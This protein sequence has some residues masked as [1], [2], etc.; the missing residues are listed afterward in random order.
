MLVSCDDLGDKFLNE[1][2]VDLE[3]P[4]VDLVLES[5]ILSSDTTVIVYF[6]RT[7]SILEEDASSLITNA[8]VELFLNDVSLGQLEEVVVNSWR[9]NEPVSVYQ[10]ELN[11][12]QIGAGDQI[13]LEATT[14]EGEKVSAIEQMP[15]AA[16]LV[17]ATYLENRQTVGYYY[18]DNSLRVVIDDPSEE[19][20][21]YVFI[22]DERYRD[23]DPVSSSGMDTIEIV[24]DIDLDPGDEFTDGD[25]ILYPI[26]S[27]LTFNGSQNTVVLG[28]NWE[29]RMTSFNEET[30]LWVR[31][32]AINKSAYDYDKALDAIFLSEG[33]PFAEPVVLP[34]S[35]EGGRGVLRLINDSSELQADLQ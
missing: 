9:D 24:R 20:N 12:A 19:E 5:T 10:L 21:R 8:V 22:A 7:R 15:A 18:A 32:G 11:G 14:P 17:S 30:Q 4:E 6:T 23:L 35:I 3:N 28:I 27:D 31:L 33:N 25:F 16:N 1:I 34:S 26:S 29:P 13:R 2:D